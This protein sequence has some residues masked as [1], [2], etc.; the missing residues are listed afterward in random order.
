[1]TVNRELFEQIANVIELQPQY[2]NQGSWATA[3]LGDIHK[4]VEDAERA[5]EALGNECGTAFCIA[6]WAVS[7]SATPEQV[8]EAKRIA[9]DEYC[10]IDV[11]RDDRIY[12][13]AQAFFDVLCEEV[14]GAGDAVAAGAK[15]LGL[16]YDDADYLFNGCWR[17][18]TGLSVP[19]ALRKIGDGAGV[20]E[21]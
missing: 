6:G 14:T 11:V 19:E 3:A 18:Q 9:R 16:G 8:K 4:N 12:V 1:M 21:V 17:P 20:R 13:N 10:L 2:Y 5:A 15:L 7:L